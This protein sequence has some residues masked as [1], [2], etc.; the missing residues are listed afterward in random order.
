VRVWDLRKP[1]E[2]QT[3][4]G[5]SSFV[6]GV[7]FAPDG[8]TIFTGSADGTGMLSDVMTL[9]SRPLP[10][11]GSRVDRAAFTPD[12]RYLLLAN[13]LKPPELWDATTMS[14]VAPLDGG[15]GG[16][17]A[18]FSADGAYAVAAAAPATDAGP[19]AAAIGLW[20]VATRSLVRTFPAVG[21][22]LGDITPDGRFVIVTTD[23][24]EHNIT[25]YDAATGQQVRVLENGSS[26]VA[27][28]AVSPDNRHIV[29]GSR[30]NTARI[31]DVE[32]GEMR[33]LVGH[34][35][36]IWGVAFSP[37]G[38]QVLTGSQDRT[39]RLWDVASGAELRRFASH[40]YSAIGGVAISP[41]GNT[42]AIGNFDG[43]TQLSPIVLANLEDDVCGRLLRDFTPAERVIYEIRDD[44]PTCK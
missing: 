31:F 6:Y 40:Q 11:T 2:S 38:R 39:S 17:T 10:Y 12:G 1:V 23:D 14:L 3:I 9:A 16:Q 22:A 30:D 41:D 33:E 15:A 4:T 36:I 25:I 32:T 18:G 8:R 29:T 26:G 5:Q 21:F 7:A 44:R 43:A 19:D 28:L 27:A 13:E 37:D 34:T 35:N 42:V 20:N 24:P